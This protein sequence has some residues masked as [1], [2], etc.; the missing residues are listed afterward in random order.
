MV[1]CFS[2]LCGYSGSV[3]FTL[4]DAGITEE[5]AEVECLEAIKGVLAPADR[6]MIGIVRDNGSVVHSC[7]VTLVC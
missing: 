7:L 6:G 3:C 1:G 2:K 4:T 5:L